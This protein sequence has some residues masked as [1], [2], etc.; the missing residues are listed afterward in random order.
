M[1]ELQAGLRLEA[2]LTSGDGKL[3]GCVIFSLLASSFAVQSDSSKGVPKPHDMHVCEQDE[4][5]LLNL[6]AP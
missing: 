6:F 5:L 3:I 1:P 4:R 2:L